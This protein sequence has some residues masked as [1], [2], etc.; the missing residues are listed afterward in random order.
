MTAT[1]STPWD[2]ATLCT[3]LAPC[4]MRLTDG[5]GTGDDGLRRSTT[6][7]LGRSGPSTGSFVMKTRRLAGS[8]ATISAP[9]SPRPLVLSKDASGTRSTVV[10]AA[11]AGAPDSRTAAGA[12]TARAVAAVVPRVR[13]RMKRKVGLVGELQGASDGQQATCGQTPGGRVPSRQVPMCG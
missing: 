10:A 9:P 3:A 13:G 4:D 12:S 6:S 2:T 1:A 7:T 5:R 8:K 11:V